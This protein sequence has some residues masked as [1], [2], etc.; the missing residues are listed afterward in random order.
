MFVRTTLPE[1]DETVALT[2]L[3]FPG[4]F[5]SL[6]TEDMGVFCGLLADDDQ[7]KFVIQTD[8]HSHISV[9]DWLVAMNL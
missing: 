2:N 9:T 1:M 8:S 6:T 4:N 3:T 7:Q 5:F